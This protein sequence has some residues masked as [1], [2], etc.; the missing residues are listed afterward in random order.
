MKNNSGKKK[1]DVKLQNKSY[2]TVFAPAV[3]PI[4]T[5]MTVPADRHQ[6]YTQGRMMAQAS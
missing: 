5:M 3:S 6:N 2:A 4:H 1:L